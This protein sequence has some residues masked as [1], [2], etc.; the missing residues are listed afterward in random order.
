MALSMKKNENRLFVIY[1]GKYQ[2]RTKSKNKNKTKQ[3]HDT[4]QPNI[5]AWETTF[6]NTYIFI[7]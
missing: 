6:R 1:V 7:C 5:S 2:S 3:K 4:I